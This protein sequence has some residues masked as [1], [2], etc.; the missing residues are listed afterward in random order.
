MLSCSLLGLSVLRGG[1]QA[2]PVKIKTD[3]DGANH[4]GRR[5]GCTRLMGEKSSSVSS[6]VRTERC[7]ID[8]SDPARCLN[9]KHTHSKQ[10]TW[11]GPQ[12]RAEST[13]K[14]MSFAGR[15]NIAHHSR[16]KSNFFRTSYIRFAFFLCPVWR[17]LLCWKRWHHLRNRTSATNMVLLSCCQTYTY[18]DVHRS[19]PKTVTICISAVS[20]GGNFCQSLT[21]VER[22]TTAA[23]V[24]DIPHTF[25]LSRWH[26][27]I[28][29]F[30]NQT[31]EPPSLSSGRSIYITSTQRITPLIWN[32]IQ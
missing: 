25:W 8:Q 7:G 4:G 24:F 1:S 27:V 3:P 6:E 11:T 15:N 17:E 22:V 26:K 12:N 2:W 13:E 19:L 10:Q 16:F 18:L 9:S 30:Q 14:A 20:G 31:H 29:C 23:A 5:E 21:K 32:D 28:Y